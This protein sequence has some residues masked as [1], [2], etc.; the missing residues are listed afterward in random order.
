MTTNVVPLKT[1]KASAQERLD[2]FANEYA[3]NGA[4]HIAAYKAAGFSEDSAHQNAK[5]YL[6]KHNEYVMGIVKRSM[7]QKSSKYTKLLESC[8]SDETVPW[9]NRLKAMEMFFKMNGF[10]K[11]SL[12][13]EEK[14]AAD[15]TPEERK[16][17]IAKLKEALEKHA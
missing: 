1:D 13:I 15:M 12:V 9:A 8:M 11:D 5:K 2:T 14:K 16:A 4:D 6:D 17:E 3:N 7:L 10:S